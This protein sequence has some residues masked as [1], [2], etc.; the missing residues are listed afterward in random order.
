MKKAASINLAKIPAKELPSSTIKADFGD[1]NGEQEFTVHAVGD[2]ARRDI[3]DVLTDQREINRNSKLQLI[4]LT[5]GL[6]CINGDKATA[7]YLLENATDA[8]ITVTA[9]IV[10]LTNEFYAAKGEEKEA[11]EKN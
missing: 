10:R 8:C 1:G 6:D 9:E 2:M 3:M 5:E 4:L 11:A 7:R